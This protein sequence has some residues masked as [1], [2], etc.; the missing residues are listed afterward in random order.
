MRNRRQSRI[1]HARSGAHPNNSYRIV[2]NMQ[3]NWAIVLFL[4]VVIAP[5]RAMADGP[6]EGHWEFQDQTDEGLSHGAE[7]DLD[8]RGESVSGTW[9]DG[10]LQRVWSGTLK[11]NARGHKLNV[12]FCSDG[13]FG[14]EAFVCPNFEPESDLFVVTGDR[15]TW[16]RRRGPGFESYAVLQRGARHRTSKKA[17]G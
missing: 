8:Q 10:S 16:Y 4:A 14:N 17:S 13:S 2:I 6:F 9:S 5:S 15:L 1:T 12:R 3:V 7:L 11:G